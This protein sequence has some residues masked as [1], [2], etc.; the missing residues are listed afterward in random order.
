MTSV[1]SGKKVDVEDNEKKRNRQ[2]HSERS[3]QWE[4]VESDEEDGN[5]DDINHSRKQR[6]SQS[7]DGKLLKYHCCGTD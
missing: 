2:E 6:R 4:I 7:Q 1:R 5:D 3:R